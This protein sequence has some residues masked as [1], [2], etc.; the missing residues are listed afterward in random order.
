MDITLDAMLVA[1]SSDFVA[2]G[3]VSTC[4][5]ANV[6]YLAADGP[7]TN[8]WVPSSLPTTH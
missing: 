5:V 6:Y 4:T 8:V 2:I 7:S 3:G 1:T